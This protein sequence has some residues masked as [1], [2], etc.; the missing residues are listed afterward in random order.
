MIAQS[1]KQHSIRSTVYEEGG[2]TAKLMGRS[3]V[4]TVESRGVWSPD[5]AGRYIF[6]N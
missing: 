5:S 3:V 2:R 6:L 4:A 1:G